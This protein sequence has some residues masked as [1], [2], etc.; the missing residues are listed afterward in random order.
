[1]SG[2]TIVFIIVAIA[3]TIGYLALPK[4]LCAWGHTWSG[5]GDAITV[6]NNQRQRRTCVKCGLI[7]D[8]LI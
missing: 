7:D 2:L 6:N 4:E 8:R 3:V 5:W 1:M